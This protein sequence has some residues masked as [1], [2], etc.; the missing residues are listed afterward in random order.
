MVDTEAPSHEINPSWQLLE[1]HLPAQS[2]LPSFAVS[3]S[4]ESCSGLCSD[5]HPGH[6]NILPA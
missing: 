2:E 6:P 1:H 3:I 4:V 5:T